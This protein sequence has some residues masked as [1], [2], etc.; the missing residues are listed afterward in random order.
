MYRNTCKYIHN[1]FNWLLIA[2][3]LP[4]LKPCKVSED[5]RA[6]AA[7]YIYIVKMSF[8]YYGLIFTQICFSQPPPVLLSWKLFGS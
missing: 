5:L 4:E 7:A 8:A 2:H 1:Q 6:D 3:S